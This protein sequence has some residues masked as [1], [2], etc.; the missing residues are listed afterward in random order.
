MFFLLLKIRLR[1]WLSQIFRRRSSKSTSKGKK[2]LYGILFIYIVGV[3]FTMS[4]VMFRSLCQPLYQ[5]GLGWFYFAIAG[6]MAF[7]LSFIGSVF[8]TWTQLYDSKDNDMLL[9]MPLKPGTILAS[10]MAMLVIL[11]FA[12]GLLVLLPAGVVWCMQQPVSVSAVIAFVLCMLLL[13]FFTMIFSSVIGFLIGQVTSRARNRNL[14]S[15][16]FSLVFVAAYFYIYSNASRL[17]KS[18]IENGQSFAEAV[19]RAL[20]PMYHFGLAISG[21]NWISLLLFALCTLVPF[22]VVYVVISRTFISTVT[23]RRGRRKAKYSRHE[24]KV[25]PVKKAMLRKELRRYFANPMYML[26]GGLG[27]LICIVGAIVLAVKAG[28]VFDLVAQIPWIAQNLSWAAA[29]I[30]C[31]IASM[32]MMSAPSISLEGKSL[33]IIKSL[34]VSAS[35]VLEAKARAHMAF[36]VPPMLLASLSCTIFLAD[37]IISAVMI[38]VLPVFFTALVAYLGVLVNLRHPFFD[39]VNETAAI[40]QSIAVIVTMLISWGILIIMIGSYLAA[41]HWSV[42]PGIPA[43]IWAAILAAVSL[44]LRRRLHSKGVE[45]FE[46]L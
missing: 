30:L 40:K 10:R 35:D 5:S 27:T 11:D 21:G 23:A 34:P 41:V 43:V 4:S 26:N 45:N 32:D 7:G 19:R 2:V 24:A 9:S 44:I 15:A 20:F 29:A 6:I 13:P 22:A 8:A 1:A 42:Q 25:Y 37:S 16:I 14:V 39:W 38:F 17:M 31:A 36:C 3:F 12:I 18:L 46:E 33:W 28:A